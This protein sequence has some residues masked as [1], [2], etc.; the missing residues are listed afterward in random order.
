MPRRF[1]IIHSVCD[2]TQITLG[3]LNLYITVHVS[4]VHILCFPLYCMSLYLLGYPQAHRRRT[5]KLTELF[6]LTCEEHGFDFYCK[7][8]KNHEVTYDMYMYE[9]PLQCIR[10]CCLFHSNSRRSCAMTTSHPDTQC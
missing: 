1:L 2:I 4:L 8:K 9:C 5:R 6:S 7:I 3:L 10:G